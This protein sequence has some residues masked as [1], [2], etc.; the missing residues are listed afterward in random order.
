MD[1]EQLFLTCCGYEFSE[2]GQSMKFYLDGPNPKQSFDREQGVR[3]SLFHLLHGEDAAAVQQWLRGRR[4]WEILKVPPDYSKERG[5][6]AIKLAFDWHS[7]QG[8][9]LYSF[10]STRRIYGEKHRQQLRVE[11][12]ALIG[13]VIENPVHVGEFERLALLREV[14]NTAPLDI[15]LATAGEVFE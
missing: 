10:A 2:D 14:I 5:I 1:I 15:E 9:P 3:T 13:D 7:G 12:N 4:A 6:A 11:V 8:S